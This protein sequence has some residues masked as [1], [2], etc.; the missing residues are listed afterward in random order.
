MHQIKDS[1]AGT[2][3]H[4]CS[5]GVNVEWCHPRWEIVG[6]HH[7]E[8]NKLISSWCPETNQYHAWPSVLNLWTKHCEQNNSRFAGDSTAQC[9]A[10]LK[11]TIVT[12]HGDNIS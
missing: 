1:K 11:A 5:P 8:I 12:N 7:R 10:H 6:S 9:C 3:L 2:Y 4:G